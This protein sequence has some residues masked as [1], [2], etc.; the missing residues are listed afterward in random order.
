[1]TENENVNEVELL[2]EKIDAL[3]RQLHAE[4][5]LREIERVNLNPDFSPSEVSRLIENDFVATGSDK[6][7][8]VGAHA[9]GWLAAKSGTFLSKKQPQRQ[10]NL[11][12]NWRESMTQEQ[13]RALPEQLKQQVRNELGVNATNRFS[14]DRNSAY[15]KARRGEM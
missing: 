11:P 10:Q 15:A 4:Q 2:H 1:M 13:Y 14:F 5:R 8:S 6:I 3:Q 9:A 12:S 7:M